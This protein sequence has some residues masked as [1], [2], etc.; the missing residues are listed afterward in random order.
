MGLNTKDSGESV[1]T[2]GIGMGIWRGWRRKDFGQC[3]EEARQWQAGGKTIKEFSESTGTGG[4]HSPM[5]GV[6]VGPALLGSGHQGEGGAQVELLAPSRSQRSTR[7]EGRSEWPWP[8]AEGCQRRP[9]RDTGPKW[10]EREEAGGP[11]GQSPALR[12]SR[13]RREGKEQVCNS[14]TPVPESPK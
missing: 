6:D 5:A 4:V 1:G 7:G 3:E 2:I 10:L 13:D 14:L 12:G 11:R 8:Q 9:E